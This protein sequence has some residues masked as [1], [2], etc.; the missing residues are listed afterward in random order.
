MASSSKPLLRISGLNAFYGQAQILE[1]VELEMGAEAISVIGRNG[2][3]KTTLLKCVM[4][5]LKA[6]SGSVFF[7]GTDLLKCQPEERARRFGESAPA[8]RLTA[9]GFRLPSHNSSIV[10]LWLV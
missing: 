10:M 5:L 1:D 7:E 4:G 3:G 6:T 9:T 8:F 2:M